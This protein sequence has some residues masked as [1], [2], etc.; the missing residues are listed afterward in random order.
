MVSITKDEARYLREHGV[1]S[2]IVRT[3]KQKSKRNNLFCCEDGY[4]LELLNEYRKSQKIV[5]E[6]PLS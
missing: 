4:T 2:G 1:K 3:M 5:Y 6:Y